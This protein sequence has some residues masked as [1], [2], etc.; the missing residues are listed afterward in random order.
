ML[1][2]VSAGW[3]TIGP[4]T[5]R[6]QPALKCAGPET[7]GTPPFSERSST[8]EP[9]GRAAYFRTLAGC[10]PTRGTRLPPRLTGFAPVEID[11]LT[12]DFEED[13]SD[14]CVCAKPC[15]T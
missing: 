12:T 14:P 11:Q 10:E 6:Y 15:P 2:I 3:L 8:R 5:G 4:I 7:T 9:Q 1:S 13:A